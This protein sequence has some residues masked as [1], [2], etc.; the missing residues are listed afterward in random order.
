MLPNHGH[1]TEHGP[2]PFGKGSV[3][4]FTVLFARLISP[5]L[6]M[7]GNPQKAGFKVPSLGLKV[8]GC[9]FGVLEAQQKVGHSKQS[10]AKQSNKK[11]H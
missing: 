11:T 2:W 6:S 10:S 1:R 8:Q 9:A 5:A 7:T 4:G 3:W